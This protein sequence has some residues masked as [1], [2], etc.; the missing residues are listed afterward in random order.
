MKDLDRRKE[1]FGLLVLDPPAF[2]KSA[3][4][5][6]AAVRGYKQINLRALRLAATGAIVATSSC[7]YHLGP[8]EF[9]QVPRDAAA[10]AGRDVT[11]V[12]MRGQ[13]P[14]HPVHLSVPETRYL[15]VAL[16]LV[17]T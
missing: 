12:E 6:V 9:L 7:S 3:G 8:E 13:A 17:R 10:D 2:T 4:A 1:R 5:V 16:L 15:K 14:D 11:L